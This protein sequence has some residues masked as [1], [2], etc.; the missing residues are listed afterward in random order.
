MFKFIK[1]YFSTSYNLGR[2]KPPRPLPTR[3]LTKEDI[4]AWRKLF[5]G[6]MA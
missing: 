4:A 2:A 5:D 6:R 1:K 3:E